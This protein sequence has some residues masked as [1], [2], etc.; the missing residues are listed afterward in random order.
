MQDQCENDEK[1]EEHDDRGGE[2]PDQRLLT[3]RIEPIGK[4]AYRAVLQQDAGDAAIADKARER[5]GA[6]QEID[7]DDQDS[8]D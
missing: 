6:G 2:G 7:V 4:A 1:Q 8:S 5:D 3:E